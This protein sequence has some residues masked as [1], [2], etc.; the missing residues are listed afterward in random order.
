MRLD[1]E[2]VPRTC[3]ALGTVTLEMITCYLLL[4]APSE[5][6]VLLMETAWALSTLLLSHLPSL[7][8][9][10]PNP[11]PTQWLPLSGV[12]SLGFLPALPLV[13]CVA[14]SH[15]PSLH[16]S[17]HLSKK[18]T[19]GLPHREGGV[20]S[21]LIPTNGLAQCPHVMGTHKRELQLHHH[22]LDFLV[23]LVP[24]TRFPCLSWQPA[25]A[26]KGRKGLRNKPK[27]PE[28]SWPT[29]ELAPS[30]PLPT[31]ASGPMTLSLEWGWAGLPPTPHP[32]GPSL[33]G[34]QSQ[35][36]L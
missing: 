17:F 31:L 15:L 24:P 9:S 16:L 34:A 11:R 19:A 4:P 27:S 30:C 8:P 21:E 33:A 12:C 1:R 3:R 23:S 32:R 13:S 36:Q 14:F 10:H 6:R 22:Y 2:G 25:L 20:F 7:F 18:G 35:Q 5:L 29:A 28:G 26:N